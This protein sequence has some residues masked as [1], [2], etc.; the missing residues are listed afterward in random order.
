MSMHR[1]VRM[2]FVA[3]LAGTVAAT[4]VVLSP[5]A[6]ASTGTVAEHVAEVDGVVYATA[7]VGD[8]TIIG[9]RFTMAGGLPRQNVAAVRADGTVDP[10]W[11]PSVNDV[12]YA[13]TGSD[14]GST[15][16]L[17]GGFT[18]VGGVAHARL[19][20]VDAKTGALV[21]G[22]KAQVK[23]NL[24]RALAAVGGR[25]YVGGSFSRIAG[26]DVNRL[27][28]LDQT[29]GAV[30]MSFA[31]RPSATVRAVDVSPDGTKVYA[32]GAFTVIAGVSRPGLAELDAATGAATAFTPTDGGVVIA[33]DTM[34]DG[35]RVFFAS[36]NNR[37]W[38]YDPALADAPAYRVRTGGDV[39]AIAATSDEVYIGGHFNTLPEAKLDRLALASFDPRDGA[40]TDWNPGANGPFGVWTITAAPEFLAIGGDFTRVGG[41]RHQGFARF[42]GAP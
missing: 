28:L 37:T 17:G 23:N 13:V 14:D 20:A 30:D 2:S 40:V 42:P 18:T 10:L 31:P 35:Q 15:I 3:L 24:V 11:D 39:Q 5:T 16:F 6:L 9:G 26:R 27:A 38:A 25:L 1:L 34:P 12:V 36:T 32:G 41:V 22:W 19:A 33:I 29:T 8:R 4:S 21:S 7:Q